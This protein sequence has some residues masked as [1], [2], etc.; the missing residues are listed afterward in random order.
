M[1]LDQCVYL[2][3]KKKGMPDICREREDIEIV[4]DD[5]AYWRKNHPLQR[6]MSDLAAEKGFNEGVG[7]FNEVMVRLKKKDIKNLK[8][9]VK[10]WKYDSGWF[11]DEDWFKADKKSTLEF[12]KKALKAIEKGYAVYYDSSW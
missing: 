6:W 4:D 2:A 3:K 7:A 1:G 8:S 9:E 10:T 5:F 12:C 11:F